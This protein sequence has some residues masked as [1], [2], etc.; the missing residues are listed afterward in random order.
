[1]RRLGS[2]LL[3]L[4]VLVTTSTARPRLPVPRQDLKPH[5]VELRMAGR[6]VFT[7]R[8]PRSGYTP[9]QRLTAAEAQLQQILERAGK[10]DVTTRQTP[11]GN[12]LFGGDRQVCA[13]RPADVDE[14]GGET[15]ETL[16]ADT[17]ARLARAL[18]ETREARS[19]N[20]WLVALAKSAAT[21]VVAGS[22]VWVLLRYSRRVSIW[23]GQLAE[24]KSGGLRSAELRVLG[25]QSVVPLA[26]G[27]TGL[28]AWSLVAIVVCLSVQR[29]LLNF[30]YSRPVGEHLNAQ[31]LD[32]VRTLALAFAESL[33]GL[34]MVVFLWL[35]ARFGVGVVRRYFQA[36]GR[37]LVESHLAEAVTPQVA[38][39]LVAALIWLGALVVAFPYIPGSSTGA[40]QG[41]TVLAG[42]MVSLGSTSLVGQMASGLVLAYSR[43]FRVGDY[44]RFGEHEG[45]V[46]AFGLLSTKIRTPVNEEVCVPNTV[47]TTGATT[48][49]SH[50][51]REPGTFL[52]TRL[53]LG[54]DV[55]WR[56]V[57]EL[58]LGAARRT[59]G[60]RGEPPPH[61]LQISLSD[62]Y[63]V[64]ELRA[65]AAEPTKRPVVLSRLLS[66]VL[67][68]FDAAG[69]KILSPHHLHMHGSLD[70]GSARP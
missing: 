48:N 46:M 37:G 57:H 67:D 18:D 47:F 42:L 14:P 43:T 1:M 61:V 36:A 34:A 60:V 7:F 41:V 30:P 55:P 9:D 28:I 22:L 20:G 58:L 56:K 39:R 2:A 23:L 70:P 24:R 5:E 40:F 35:C 6:T 27:L 65:V 26:R 8:A 16:S 50:F 32:Q 33:P 10:L 62:F 64:Y 54:Y 12:R 19:L 68:D 52:T 45:P 59:E 25:Q 51:I 49:Y 17:A 44:V 38:E 3:V 11:E 63:I 31:L 15:L 4:P 53:S 29:L 21:L 66:N 69:V 13:V